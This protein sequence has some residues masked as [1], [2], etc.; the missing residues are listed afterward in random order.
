[1][2]NARPLPQGLRL[3]CTSPSHESF[4]TSLPARITDTFAMSFTTWH[5]VNILPGDMSISHR[6]SHGLH[7]SS[8]TQS[9]RR[10]GHFGCCPPSPARRPSFSPV[11]SRA[12]W[13]SPLGN[14]SCLACGIDGARP[15]CPFAPV[16]H[17]RLR[18][19]AL[20]GDRLS[21]RAHRQD[22]QRA[23]LACRRRSG[24]NYDPE[25][26]RHRLLALRTGGRHPPHAASS[27]PASSLVLDRLSPSRQ[28]SPC[29]TFS[30]NGGISFH[31]S[32]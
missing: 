29:P 26:I 25:Q 19:A 28:P 12:S 23:S 21:H 5:A 14:V 22:R 1:M 16:H 3:S 18:P 10:S 9:A 13:W 2:A 32:S 17:E 6:S 8:S 15:A 7:G 20:D 11:C 27:M 30:G 24:G 4:S 31:F